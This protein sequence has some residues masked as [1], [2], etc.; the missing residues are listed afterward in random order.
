MVNGIINEA[1]EKSSQT[2]R[3]SIIE[4]IEADLYNEKVK[5]GEIPYKYQLIEIINNKYGVVEGESFTSNEGNYTIQL[6]EI[7]GWEN[8]YIQNKLTL[9][10]DAIN[11]SGDGDDNHS[12]TTN[13]WRNLVKNENNGNIIGAVWREN[14]LELDGV[15]SWVNLGKIINKNTVTVESTV[16]LKSIPSGNASILG[17]WQN[18]GNG[19]WIHNGKACMGVWTEGYQTAMMNE[20]IGTSQIYHICGTYDGNTVKLYING[21]LKETVS[22]SGAIG[23]PND[24]TVMAIGTNPKGDKADI[25][26]SN[27]NIYSARIYDKALSEIEIKNNY[28][29]DKERFNF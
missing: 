6:A 19:I 2:Q 23:N 29:I 22:A 13:E 25:E 5:R 18:G 15:S 24:N 27:A 17:N 10:L 1:K 20:V 4:K 26:F 3:A 9:H 12:T 28:Q 7:L 14:Y 8:R 11:N 16:M 21:E